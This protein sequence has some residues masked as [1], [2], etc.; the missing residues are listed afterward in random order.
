MG[1][2]FGT[3]GIRGVA[4][5]SPL[6]RETV[7]RVGAA[8]ARNLDTPSP[9]VLIGRDTRRSGP[10]I[11]QWL[12][13]GLAR[14]GATAE[15]AGVITTPAIAFL[16]RS[17]GF[18]A[19]VVISAS[20]NAYRDNG[21]KIFG[22]KGSKSNAELEAR[23][24]RDVRS[25]EEVPEETA[26]VSDPD[27]RFEELYLDHLL[28]SLDHSVRLPKL[29]IALDCA[30][31]AG[32]RVGPRLLRE[33]GLVVHP[34]CAEPDGENINQNCGSTHI[35]TLRGQVVEKGCSL[36]AALDGDGDRLLMVDSE[37]RLVDGDGL[38]LLCA[39]RFKKEG[40]AGTSGV[41]A[42]VMSNMALERAL[43]DEGMRLHRAAVGDKFVAHE[44]AE[45]NIILG[46]EQSGH[47]IFS[48]HGFTGDGL[49]TLVQ[50]L[51]I[52]ALE[53]Q[54][55]D[56]L[57]RLDPFPQVLVNVRVR[58]RPEIHEV[59]A[60]SKAIREAERQLEGRGR[61]LI[62]Y[63][64]TEPLLR[65]MMEGPDRSEIETLADRVEESA[66]LSIGVAH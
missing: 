3:D 47:I 53:G 24:E 2:L 41:V 45:R 7:S 18:D 35:D 57:G 17:E 27:P 1:N 25:R 19:G 4:Y 32:Y 64:G 52:M 9:R 34:I 58:E 51:R 55:L 15:S 49:L 21:I 38:L 46:G 56:E 6:D 42:T 33:L 40:R 39:R 20:H 30:N 29:E 65:I 23:I 63:S 12:M 37:G 13:S 48:D 54:S 66:R 5:E 11:E 16:T 59:P 14:G 36:G 28:A 31:G 43:A 62:R 44:M 8:L 26:A 61:V 60:L 50:V 22:D 10:D